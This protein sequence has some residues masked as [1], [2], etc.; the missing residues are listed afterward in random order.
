MAEHA[1]EGSHF[2][3]ERLFYD[4]IRLVEW[5]RCLTE[6]HFIYHLPSVHNKTEED[7]EIIH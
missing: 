6:C 5:Q 4:R 7:S 3:P 2:I 1:T